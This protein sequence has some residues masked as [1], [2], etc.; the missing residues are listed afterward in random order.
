[1]INAKWFVAPL[2]AVTAPVV[3]IGWL[4]LQ[5][6][7]P[8]IARDFEE[9][10]EQAKAASA[11]QRAPLLTDCGARFAGRRKPN[12]GYSYYDFMQD[13]SFDIAGPNPT[14]DERKQ[15]DR[16]Y[17]KYLDSVRRDVLSAELAQQ[18]NNISVADAIGI[19]TTFRPTIGPPILLTPKK[20][21][22]AKSTANRSKIAPVPCPEGSLACHWE[23]LTSAVRHA[24]ASGSKPE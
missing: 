12:G 23:K 9:C 8:G 20:L 21:P 6:S 5:L 16:E 14:A 17:M 18:Q 7:A 15:I 2:I 11:T 13:R 24:F 22:S 19:T 4:R 3:V 1:M 10:A